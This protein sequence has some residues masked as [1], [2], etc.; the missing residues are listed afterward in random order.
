[1][2]TPIN[3]QDLM[4][5]HVFDTDLNRIGYIN[6]FISVQWTEDYYGRG[7]FILYCVDSP[8]YTSLLQENFYLYRIARDTA[9]IIRKVKCSSKDNRI[10]VR[11]Y[12]TNDLINQRVIHRTKSVNNV[13]AGMYSLVQSANEDN[14]EY[15]GLITADPVGLTDQ[16]ETQFTGVD[17]LESL[18][19][20]GAE[21]QIGFY[22]KFDPKAKQ[23]IFTVYKG[24]DRTEG[25]RD[26]R[27]AKFSAELHNLKN[28]TIITDLSIFRNVAYVA[29]GGEGDERVWVVVND[30]ISGRD[31]YELAV[32]A[33]DLQQTIFEDGEETKYTDEEY[34]QLLVARGIKKLNEHMRSET[35]VAEVE[36]AGFGTDYYLGDL[37]SC[38]SEKYNMRIDTRILRYSETVDNGIYRLALTMGN[39]E[40]T[41][42]GVVKT[43]RS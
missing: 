23:H 38:K 31:R 10:E 29:G 2:T 39:P 30:E 3:Y 25:Q 7:E 24:L 37:V 32:D 42:W 20:L 8:Y 40:I 6:N 16:F 4:T 34:K 18:Q 41:A 11:G 36:P 12:T 17:L 5:L 9:M 26:N 19:A 43:W 13:E 21:A 28:V 35:F 1:M 22:T 27:P 14:R 33:R 15:P